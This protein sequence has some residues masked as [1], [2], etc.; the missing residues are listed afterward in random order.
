MMNGRH[1]GTVS[2]AHE[3]SYMSTYYRTTDEQVFTS[4]GIAY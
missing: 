2:V 3:P 4:I 1:E